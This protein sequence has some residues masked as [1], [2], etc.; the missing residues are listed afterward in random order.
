LGESVVLVDQHPSLISVPAL[1]NTYTTIAMNLRHR[2]DV[3]AVGGA[4]LLEEEG[5]H[6]LGQLPVGWA[7]VK[8][9]GR[10]TEPF[11]VRVPHLKQPKGAMTDQRLTQLSGGWAINAA[12][13]SGPSEEGK[14]LRG[15]G[16]SLP[17]QPPST[18]RREEALLLDVGQHPLSGVVERYRRLRLNRRKGNAAKE[19]C[20]ERGLLR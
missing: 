14:P 6:L 13:T 17:D 3:N 8:L 1:G 2:S 11:V 12:G 19:R 10:W 16:A 9:Q 20:L 7:I 4:M 5:K 15:N 18:S